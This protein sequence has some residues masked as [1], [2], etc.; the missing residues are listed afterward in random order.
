[1]QLAI[2]NN[3]IEYRILASMTTT[4]LD[5]DRAAAAVEK[6]LLG[7]TYTFTYG[8]FWHQPRTSISCTRL[9]LTRPGN[10][11]QRNWPRPYPACQNTQ[12]SADRV[13]F[14]INRSRRR[15]V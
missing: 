9:S 12:S 4:S 14:L 5:H 2:A 15:T 11:N 8:F 7:V 6:M 13:L 1:M 10:D 3:H